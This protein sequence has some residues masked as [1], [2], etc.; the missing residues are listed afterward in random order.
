MVSQ[1]TRSSHVRFT[2]P[3]LGSRIRDLDCG[4]GAQRP[5]ASAG[6]EYEYMIPSLTALERFLIY[7]IELAGGGENG[8]ADGSEQGP[9]CVPVGEADRRSGV[10]AEQ[11]AEIRASGG[12]VSLDINASL[13]CATSSQLFASM[14]KDHALSFVPSPF[15]ILYKRG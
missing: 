4:G 7:R 3:L 14:L 10:P 6:R 11:P 1:S 12:Q 8:T 15:C 9:L 5:R 13:E 2:L